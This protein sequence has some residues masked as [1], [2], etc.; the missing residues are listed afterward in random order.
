MPKKCEKLMYDVKFHIL[1]L[2]NIFDFWTQ[3]RYNLGIA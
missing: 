3:I 1:L 2:I